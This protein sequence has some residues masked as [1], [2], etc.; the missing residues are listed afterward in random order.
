MTSPPSAM[1]RHKSHPRAFTLI[2]LLVIIGIIAILAAF[3][4]PAIFK[5]W[6]SGVATKTKADLQAISNALENFKQ[7]TGDYPRLDA[8]NLGFAV[9]ARA[10]VA[11]GE[12]AKYDAG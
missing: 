12:T 3:A 1:L 7:D 2:E 6:K 9:L 4:V 5:A 10:L 8:P 11:P